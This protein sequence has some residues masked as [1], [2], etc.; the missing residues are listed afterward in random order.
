MELKRLFEKYK[1]HII[2]IL[3]LLQLTIVYKLIQWYIPSFYSFKTPYDAMIPFISFFVVP[4]LLYLIVMFAPFFMAWKDKAMFLAVSS[5]F[6]FAVTICNIIF[7][8]FPTAVQRPEVITS[9]VF[10]RLVLLVYSIDGILNCFP[11]EHIVFSV[12]ACLCMFHINKKAA[13]IM[14]AITLLIIPSTL[15]IKQHY[16]PDIFGGIVLSLICY[17]FVFRIILDKSKG[18]EKAAKHDVSRK[19]KPDKRKK[20]KSKR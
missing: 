19:T 14:S 5:A 2:V 1:P 18:K 12:L 4:Y 9:S 7:I 8:I 16:I 6:L 15:L 3:F 11:S 10:D 17:F 20:K 13:W